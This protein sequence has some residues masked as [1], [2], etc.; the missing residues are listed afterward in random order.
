V[1]VRELN[2]FLDRR[3]GAGEAERVEIDHQIYARFG[4]ERAVLISDMSGFSKTTRDHGI[5][6]FLGLIRRMRLLCQP[7][8]EAAGGTLIKA[9]A[10]NLFAV[11][12]S[13]ADAVSAG[14]AMQSACRQANAGRPDHE[15]VGVALGI[16]FGRILDLDG[17][18]FFGHE[19]NL[20]SKLGEDTA[21]GG[22]VL[23]TEAA[24]NSIADKPPAD[25][26]QTE[27]SGLRLTYW[28]VH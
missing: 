28:A 24:W 11:F 12:D 13:A 14:R 22:E 15:H 17:A 7:A 2:D 25:E 9:E 20:A 6:H 4:A 21:E 23:L 10:D 3:D 8:I 1:P 26:R 19:V 5:V 18:D 16:G 27:V